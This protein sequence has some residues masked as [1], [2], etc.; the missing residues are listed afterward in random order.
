MKKKVLLFGLFF[1]T[2]CFIL[3]SKLFAVKI[4]V[5]EQG[6]TLVYQIQC[7]NG[8]PFWSL[9]TVPNEEQILNA[10]D[11]CEEN[12]H[13]SSVAPTHVTPRTRESAKGKIKISM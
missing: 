9:Q 5:I 3:S 8:E 12:G 10:K 1:L 13:D 2:L 4:D 6:D 11:W 7:D